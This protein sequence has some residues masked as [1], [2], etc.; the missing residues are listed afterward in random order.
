MLHGSSSN[1]GVGQVTPALF[2]G[3]DFS[4]VELI[5]LM[6][7]KQDNFGSPTINVRPQILG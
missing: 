5:E 4:K 2:S 3:A 7:I 1:T 6:L